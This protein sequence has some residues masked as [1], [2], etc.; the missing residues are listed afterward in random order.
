MAKTE[1]REY[2]P[3]LL[4]MI[5]NLQKQLA[6]ACPSKADPADLVVEYGRHQV[7][8]T[9][10]PTRNSVIVASEPTQIENRKKAMN[11]INYLAK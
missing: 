5:G 8:V 2:V 9:H 10:K 1:L 7:T 11:A 3:R 4:S 6:D